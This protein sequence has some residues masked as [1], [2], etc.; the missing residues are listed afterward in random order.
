MFDS[1][2]DYSACAKA[3]KVPP[4]PRFAFN[5]GI[6]V[7]GLATIMSGGLGCCHATVSKGANIGAMRITGVSTYNDENLTT[8]EIRAKV[9]TYLIL[10]VSPLCCVLL[11]FEEF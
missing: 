8:H 9:A 2:G 3:A 4:P 1:I 7:E 6:A 11:I 5:R 10:S